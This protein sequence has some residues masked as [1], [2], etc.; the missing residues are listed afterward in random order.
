MAE[1]QPVPHDRY[2]AA[3]APCIVAA[4]AA[5]DLGI[6]LCLEFL[7]PATEEAA[8]VL[9]HDAQLILAASDHLDFGQVFGQYR[10]KPC[11]CLGLDDQQSIQIGQNLCAVEEKLMSCTAVVKRGAELPRRLGMVCAEASSTEMF[12]RRLGMEVVQQSSMRQV[13]RGMNACL[14]ALV[15]DSYN[16]VPGRNR[17]EEA[18]VRRA[19]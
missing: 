6:R 11:G 14:L 8:S 16:A 18:V 3:Q 4:A 13:A 19:C 17:C 10:R 2:I 7:G 12:L 1:V 5:A 15:V 9:C